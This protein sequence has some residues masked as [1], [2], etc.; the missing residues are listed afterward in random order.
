VVTHRASGD[1]EFGRRDV[2][3][4][5]A[6]GLQK[7]DGS[8]PGAWTRFASYRAPSAA[9]ARCFSC[10]G[11]AIAVIATARRV[12]GI[13]HGLGRFARAALG[14]SGPRRA[15]PITAITIVRTGS[16]VVHGA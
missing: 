2:G 13:R 16:A 12:A 7:S 9:A 6:R 15:A 3:R 10:A 11:G 8:R 14:T 1:R 5:T 4:T